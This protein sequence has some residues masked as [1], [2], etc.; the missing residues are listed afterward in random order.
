[1]NLTKTVIDS[2]IVQYTL[3]RRGFTRVDVR[4]YADVSYM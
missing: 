4:H 2:G 1:M 3:G